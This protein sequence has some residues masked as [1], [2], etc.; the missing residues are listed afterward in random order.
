MSRSTIRE[1]VKILVSKNILAIERGRGTFVCND[2]GV[3]DD[4]FGLEFINRDI[5][6][7]DLYEFRKT[8]EPVVCSLA[9]ERATKK[10]K[11]EMES[12]IEKM[13]HIISENGD[14]ESKEEIIDEMTENEINFHTLLYKM[15]NNIIFIRL[16]PIINKSIV[17][18]YMEL[19]YRKGYINK[20]CA[21]SHREIYEIICSGN[22]EEAYNVCKQHMI[23]MQ[24]ML[25][26][27]FK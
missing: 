11:K 21:D 27:V 8:V 26:G 10:Q 20:I 9:A 17:E 13:V 19:D 3:V 4:P 24:N 23:I 18:N 16:I 12:L 14:S 1:A 2:P 6:I 25:K 5:L 22:K 15:S 7:D